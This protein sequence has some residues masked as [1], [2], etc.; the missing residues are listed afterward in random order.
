MR[1]MLA[2]RLRPTS[3]ADIA[4]AGC[5]LVVGQV[6]VFAPQLFK[7][8]FA[9]PKWVIGVCWGLSAL[10]LAWRRV[11][12]FAVFAVVI[13]IVVLQVLVWGPSSGNGALLPVLLASYAVAAHGTRR[14]AYLS[15]ALL[16]LAMVLRELNNP[17]DVDWAATRTELVWDLMPAVAWLAGSWMRARRLYEAS[18][19]D[20][21]VQAD[22]ERGHALQRAIIE[23]RVRIARD[24]HDSIAHALT[25][26]VVQAEAADDALDRNPS[27]ARV[28][29][30]RIE[31]TGRQALVEMREVVGALRS[32][33][34]ADAGA[35]DGAASIEN[36][37]AAA[38]RSGLSP[39]LVIHRRAEVSAALDQ[40]AYRVVQEA[41][42]N[43]LRHSASQSVHVA[44]DYGP[45][46]VEVD[47]RDPGPSRSTS[48]TP[49]AGHGLD[50]MRER[51]ALFGGVLDAGPPPGGG[52]RVHA[53]IPNGPGS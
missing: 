26:I 53:A 43:V 29:V 32:E 30:Q 41:L 46:G 42:T 52:F 8:H 31:H 14:A 9:G 33:H 5:V 11:A 35:R 27:A 17:A 48:S 4:L 15:L 18:L 13:G 49:G 3:R 44:V 50:G 39:R 24:L 40:T 51:V 10:A 2:G 47:V 37:V 7:T 20:R 6:D 34:H 36:L 19:L 21:A 28:P 1:R 45:G 22:Q 23:E 38:G 16:V 12:P 25:A